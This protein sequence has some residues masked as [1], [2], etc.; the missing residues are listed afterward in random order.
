[1]SRSTT[2]LL[3]H[4][5]AYATQAPRPLYTRLQSLAAA[6]YL[7]SAFTLPFVPPYL[8]TKRAE[9][10]GSASTRAPL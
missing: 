10:N 2:F 1:M 6:G 9:A 8:A 3:N 7:G 5:R 4:V